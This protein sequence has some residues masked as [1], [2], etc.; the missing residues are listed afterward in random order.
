ML[1][2]ALPLIIPMQIRRLFL[3]IILAALQACSANQAT[4]TAW[5]DE[6]PP[7]EYFLN[8]YQQDSTNNNIQNLDQYMT[9]VIRFYQGSELYPN[10]WNSVT[11]TLLL[12]IKDL[13]SANGVE[14]KMARLGLLISGEW[15]KNNST[16]LINTRHISIWG[17]AL[18][19]S[20]EH[21]ETLELI[22][23]VTADV[24][25]LLAS[26]IS[27]DVITENRFYAEE[28]ILQND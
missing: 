5:P 9:W 26:R 23:R 27:S 10:G 16:R 4:E 15:A 21:G 20:L 8:L 6:L 22:D 24:E 28:D 25:D 17:N 2:I 1:P 3:V 19:K 13:E 18:L 11:Q 12:G 14:D 7:H